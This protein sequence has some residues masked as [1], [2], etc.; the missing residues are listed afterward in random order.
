[1]K[2]LV[3]GKTLPGDTLISDAQSRDARF[4]AEAQNDEIGTHLPN[5]YVLSFF[6]LPERMKNLAFRPAASR[7]TTR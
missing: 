7:G 3:L 4:F 1:M 6:S 2:N 5:R